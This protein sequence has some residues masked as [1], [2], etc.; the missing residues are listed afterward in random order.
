MKLNSLYAH[1]LAFLAFAVIPALPAIGDDQSDP[2]IPTGSLSASPSV[3]QAGTYP[4]LEWNITYPETVTEVVEI[5]DPGVIT[6]KEDLY[7]DV[8][9]LGASVSDGHTWRKVEAWIAADGD[10]YY[11]R[12][13]KGTQLEVNPSKI[14]FTKL[15]RE[16]EEN[17]FG[18]RYIESNGQTQTFYHTANT[19]TINVRAL[20]NGSSPPNYI[21][22]YGQGNISS[23]L[24]PYVDD[25]GKIDIGP[26]DVIYIF[27]L[28][29]TDPNGWGFDMQDLVLLVTFRRV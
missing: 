17:H 27:D 10:Y 24:E 25:Q 2:V 6:P 3:V 18:G 14:Y 22:A 8:R 21:S 11:D 16:G 13:F 26:M 5:V 12:F 9:V 29:H 4:S 23:F 7:M 1:T 28:T 20:V 15:V 19:N